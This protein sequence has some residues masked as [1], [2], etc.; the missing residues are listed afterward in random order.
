MPPSVTN[1]KNRLGHLTF[2]VLIAPRQTFISVVVAG[3]AE[4]IHASILRCESKANLNSFTRAMKDFHAA[5][6]R[7]HTWHGFAS[8]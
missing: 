3:V 6:C 2:P 8:A 4:K 1:N 7:A 5:I